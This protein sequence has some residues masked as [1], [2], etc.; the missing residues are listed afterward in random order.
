MLSR[1]CYAGVFDR[2]KMRRS[3]EPV[4]VTALLLAYPTVLCSAPSAPTPSAPTTILNLLADAIHTE[5]GIGKV[6][7][8]F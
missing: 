5:S 6:M 2:F 4:Q 1:P 3:G 7:C 8:P